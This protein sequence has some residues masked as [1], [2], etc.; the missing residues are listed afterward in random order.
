MK[1]AVAYSYMQVRRK[2]SQLE[3]YNVEVTMTL[4]LT[5]AMNK[6]VRSYGGGGHLIYLQ[7]TR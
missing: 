3:L 4:G 6:Q 5:L 7:K 1:A 2:M